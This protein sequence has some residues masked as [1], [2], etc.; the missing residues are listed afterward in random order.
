MIIALSGRMHSGKSELA[1]ICEA[2][3]FKILKF[4]DGLKNLICKLLHID[5]YYLE[6]SKELHKEYII[7]YEI[8]S[9]ELD[10]PIEYILAKRKSNIFLSIREI[11]QFIG[12]DII[13]NYIPD[14][15]IHRLEKNIVAGN[16]YCI[17]DL[18]FENE[19]KFIESISGESW[20]IMRT[21]NFLISNHN[22]E[23]ALNWKNF[24][25]NV[26]IN[27]VNLN[28]FKKRWVR[29]LKNITYSNCDILGFLDKKDLRQ[30]LCKKL[31]VERLSTTDL[32]KSHGC[33]RDKIVWWCNNLL[34]P[35]TKQ[36][37]L[38]NRYAF[39]VATSENS[40]YAGL[41]ASDGCVKK[42]GYSLS[43]YIIEFDSTDRLLVE[44]L[45]NYVCANKP[46]YVKY[47][48]GYGSKKPLY[49]VTF[50]DP[51]IIE[52]IKYWNLLPN[53]SCKEQI[54]DILLQDTNNLKQW[55]VGLIDGDGSVFISKKTLGV[56][57]LSS[58]TV[59]DFLYLNIPIKGS[60]TQHKDTELFELKWFNYKAV[61]LF[62]W[63]SPKRC[64][65]RKWSNVNKFLSFN[66][67]RKTLE[68]IS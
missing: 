22:S 31:L 29:Y 11:M 4:A 26:I 30:Y 16:N 19:K 41:L 63:L 32:A 42:S 43:R 35:L 47:K 34:V 37:Y 67:K 64:L 60:I 40:Y 9:Y 6:N 24:E 13:R 28:L 58:K 17:D 56:T 59:V 5:R 18:R 21:D 53:K 2:N 54:P 3:G 66:T 23:T 36:K 51:Y 20:Y 33:S 15:H 14:W 49:C 57:I 55:I 39:L 62:N 61:D 68:F 50:E 8:L 65:E 44:S 25:N 1:K 7:S 27:N 45:R 46:I 52:N 48:S 38:Y 12:T 10:I